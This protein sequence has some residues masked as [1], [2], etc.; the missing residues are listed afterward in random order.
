MTITVFVPTE[1]RPPKA[2]EFYRRLGVIARATF[3]H[4]DN[5]SEQIG[6]CH[7]L[8]V[9]EGAESF[10]PSFSVHD[11]HGYRIA[12]GAIYSLPRRPKP[13]V[14]KYQWLLQ[15]KNENSKWLTD[16]HY[17]IEE[18]KAKWPDTA[19]AELICPVE[20][21]MIEVEE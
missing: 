10:S 16:F 1:F 11:A 20:E 5:E 9:P 6:I 8:E 21:T 2:G 7:S 17:T 3:D 14:K 18:A 13:K 4:N 15:W 19:T 12:I